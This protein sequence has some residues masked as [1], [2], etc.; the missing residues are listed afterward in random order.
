[1]SR[2]RQLGERRGQLLVLGRADRRRPRREHP[3]GLDALEQ[4]PRATGGDRDARAEHGELG[5]VHAAWARISIEPISAC[6]DVATR[7]R[8]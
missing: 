1:M 6:A 2:P 7:N 4:L 5:A 3:A 8:A